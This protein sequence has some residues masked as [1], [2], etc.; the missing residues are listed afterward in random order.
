MKR[1]KR[2]TKRSRKRTTTGTRTTTRKT[3][4][5]RTK[6]TLVLAANSASSFACGA[7]LLAL[8]PGV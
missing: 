5:T 7:C 2:T 3:P 1:R 4:R 8:D 6:P